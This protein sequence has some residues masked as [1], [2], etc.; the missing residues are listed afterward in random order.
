MPLDWERK[1]Q[2]GD[3]PWE[4]SGFHQALLDFAKSGVL[5]G[6]P[7]VL[8][9]G[10]GRGKEVAVLAQFGCRVTAVDI[11]P[12]AVVWQKNHLEGLGLEA[13]VIEADGLTFRPETPADAIYEQT[14]LC[15]IEPGQRADYARMALES[16]RPGGALL[17]LFMQKKDQEGGPPYH[18][19][20]EDMRALF[21]DSQWIW[22]ENLIDYPRGDEAL[23]EM[24]GILTKR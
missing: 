19:A 18:C 21:P 17:A 10:C 7:R 6:A 24:G 20:T 4:L 12:S 14:F 22:P 11:A 23:T 8:V 5:G 1:F 2:D 3:T 13:N 15:A 16:L 9:P